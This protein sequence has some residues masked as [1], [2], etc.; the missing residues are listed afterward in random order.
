MKTY[1]IGHTKPDTD[2]V[3]AAMATAHLF[4]KDETFL[5]PNA[6]AVIADPLNPETKFLFEKFELEIPPQITA[7]QIKPED[8]VVLV[9]HNENY[10]R[11]G[12]LNPEQ[13]VEII[14]HHKPQLNLGQPIFLNFKV[15]GSTSTIIYYFMKQQGIMPEAKLAGLM[16]AAILSDTVGYKSPTTTDKDRKFG[17][18][19]ANLA[20]IK[21]VE[22]FTLEIFKAKSDI[23]SLT[24]EQI[25]RNDFKI[26]EFNKK[27]FI[28]Q[29]ETVEQDSILNNKKDSLL[30]AMQKTKEAE[31]VELLFVAITDILKVNTILLILGEEEARVAEK[32]FGGQVKDHTLDIGSKL[33]RKKEIAPAIEKALA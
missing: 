15:W 8:Q 33:S 31:G 5:R 20:G 2:S 22:A 26:F 3:V 6:L 21:D 4:Q 18:E 29:L 25:V 30:K 10:Q 12:G 13:I 32:A 23:S 11:L 9:D 27:T 7:D 16:L 19:L 28:D 1:I 14:D 24:D 17:A